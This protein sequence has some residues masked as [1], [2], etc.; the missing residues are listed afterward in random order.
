ML[1]KIGEGGKKRREEKRGERKEERKKKKKKKKE[2]R[3]VNVWIFVWICMEFMFGLGIFP[4][5]FLIYM[6]VRKNSNL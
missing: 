4:T 5:K 6:L 1:G 3:K 2:E